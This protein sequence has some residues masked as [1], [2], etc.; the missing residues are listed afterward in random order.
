MINT[1][2]I[3]SVIG[4]L[5]LLE[6]LLLGCCL[7][8]SLYAADGIWTSWAAAIAVAG[9]LGLFLLQ[10]GRHAQNRVGRRDGYLVVSLTWIVFSAVGTLPFIASGREPRLAA[11][12]F[13][14]M[15]GFTTTGATI[16]TD[17]ESVEPSLLFWRSLMHWVGGV[18]IVFFTL[19][20]LPE[21][22]SGSQKIFSAEATGLKVGKLHPRISTTVHWIISLYVLLTAV[23]A[24]VLYVEGM[25]VFD[26]VN[27]AMTALSTGGFSTHTESVAWFHSPRIELT[28]TL[29]MLL[30][31]IRFT[32]L[33]M[34]IIRG[35]WRE[36]AAD[37]EVRF[38]LGMVLSVALFCTLA[39]TLTSGD[40]SL[41][42]L[43]VH[44]FHAASIASTTG[45]TTGNFMDITHP[46]CWLPLL[47]LTIMG[48]CAGS[49]SGGVKAIRLLT[50]W[51]TA[52]GEFRRLLHP[53]A[54]MPLRVGQTVISERIEHALFAYF[55]VMAIVIALSAGVMIT[56]GYPLLDSLS[57]SLTSF[58]NVG[59][60]LGWNIT[61]LD[62]WDSLPDAVL[63]ML[64][65][66]ML[67]GRLEIFSLLL[68]FVPAF[69]ENN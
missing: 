42:Q 34:L 67:C 56:M 18:G 29:F 48:G 66:V 10:N 32:L 46:A 33:Y 4:Q 26:A 7:G 13:E 62:A 19:A 40:F 25:S 41:G 57:L 50:L 61:P 9:G 59:P 5:L 31:S 52:Q 27:H 69:W 39:D 37:A 15:S 55:T 65:F 64:S 53:R 43:R 22:G 35:R 36:V 14:T 68:P 11:A 21:S 16:L 47:L 63:W 2:I 17:L 54:V 30:A 49:T 28:L 20:F 6:A 8:M 24:G 51:R 45:L 38:F 60:G 44:L 58:A 1:R 3:F 23:C 12:F